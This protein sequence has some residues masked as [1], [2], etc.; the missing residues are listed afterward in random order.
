M[1]LTAGLFNSGLFNGGLFNGGLF[2]SSSTVSIVSLLFG[3]SEPGFI[4]DISDF[5]TMFQDSAG[6]TPVTDVAQPVGKILDITGNNNHAYQ[7]TA[8]SRPILRQD[9]SGYYYLECDGVGDCLE[10]SAI[11]FTSTNK[12]SIF[13]GLLKTSSARGMLFEMSTTYATAGCTAMDVDNGGNYIS[14][15]GVANTYNGHM[16]ASDSVKYVATGLLDT[17]V[18][19][20]QAVGRLNGSQVV[21]GGTTASG[22]LANVATYIGR[23]AGTVNPFNGRIY[24][25]IVRGAASSLAEIMAAES[26]VAGKA[27][28]TL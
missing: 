27:G 11:N 21:A 10:T 24:S 26:Y 6:T 5:S 3:A 8:A 28:V 4:Y 15:Y 19:S 13:T 25:L 20:N 23:R 14:V 22:N 16:A 18:A 9:E 17:S 1:S 7:S 12:I 2:K